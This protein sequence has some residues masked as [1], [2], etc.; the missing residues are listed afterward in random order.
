MQTTGAN[1]DLIRN[2]FLRPAS[3]LVAALLFLLPFVEIRCNGATMAEN[4]G[5]GMAIG[6]DFKEAGQMKSM[7]DDFETEN[8]TTSKVS[9]GSG[10]LFEGAFIAL[11]LALAA[12]IIAFI[13]RRTARATFFLGIL[14]AL[15]MIVLLIQVKSK[16]TDK[17]K[18]TGGDSPFGNIDITA[19]F[20]PW[21]WISL[22]LLL[23]GV[24]ISY[25]QS[26]PVHA[27][28]HLHDTPPAGAPQTPIN[29]PGDQSDFPAAPRESDIG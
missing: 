3:F 5:L 11:A 16:I 29:N 1:Q 23:A 9:R 8:S 26:R 22:L 14:S 4:S 18:T 24:Y 28:G 17:S 2:R 12:A 7:K 20:T 25:V 15:S 21:Y 27:S 19:Q 6:R 13:N 10:E